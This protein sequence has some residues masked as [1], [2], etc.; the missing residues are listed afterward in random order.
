MHEWED[1]LERNVLHKITWTSAHTAK[2]AI[3]HAPFV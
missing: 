2:F 3:K 1:S